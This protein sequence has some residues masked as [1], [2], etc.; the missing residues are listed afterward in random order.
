MVYGTMGMNRILTIQWSERIVLGFSYI[1][2]LYLKS[3]QNPNFLGPISVSESNTS[4]DE[5]KFPIYQFVFF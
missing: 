4:V 5:I 3:I 2:S 1:V